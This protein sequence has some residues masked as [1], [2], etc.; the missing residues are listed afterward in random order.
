MAN[1]SL[2][3]LRSLTDSEIGDEGCRHLEETLKSNSSLTALQGKWEGRGERAY[4][5]LICAYYE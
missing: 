5:V 3:F 2:L 4:G 1:C